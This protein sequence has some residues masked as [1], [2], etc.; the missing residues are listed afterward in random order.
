MP[1]FPLG[2]ELAFKA[3]ARVPTKAAVEL[4]GPVVVILVDLPLTV[5]D[6]RVGLAV[7]VLC[8]LVAVREGPD[9]CEGFL[10]GERADT[11]DAAAV[12]DEVGDDALQDFLGSRGGVLLY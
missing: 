9:V 5:V 12:E 3:A 8:V 2:A 10:V 1:L 7:A 11:S 6:D 4:L